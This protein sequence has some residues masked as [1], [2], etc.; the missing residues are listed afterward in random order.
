MIIIENFAEVTAQI[1]TE[2][3][4]SREELMVAVQQAL[5]S[6]CKKRFSEGTTL[7]C[8]IHPETG[9]AQIFVIKTVADKVFNPDIDI[10]LSEAQILDPK[11]EVGDDVKVLAQLESF[12]RIA[13]QTAKQVIIQ[14]IREAEKNAILSEFQEK[15]GTIIIGTVQKIEGDNYL[16][17]LGRVESILTLRDQIHGERFQVNEKIKV[18]VSE[19]VKT[20]RGPSIRIS[21]SHPGL[22]KCLFEQEIPEI[23]DGIIEILSVS[24]EAGRRA[25]VAVKTN[26]PAVGAVGT[27]V[28]H[29]GV[30]IQTI[31]KEIGNEKIDI[32][33]FEEDPKAYISNALK[34]AEISEVII[35]DEEEKTGIV[36]VK[37]DQLSL[38]IGK[39]GMNVRLAVKLTGWR[40]DILSEEDYQAKSSEIKDKTHVSIV[41]RIQEE[42]R[43][44]KDESGEDQ[45]TSDDSSVSEDSEV[46]VSELSKEL[47]FKTQELIDQCKEHGIEIKNNR[48]KLSLETVSEIKEKLG[49]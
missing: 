9:E 26:N 40:I 42:A 41:D 20:P 19:I 43:K 32:I 31:I 2:R 5:V 21:R 45:E 23:E 22:L 3:G 15:V 27:C 1:E 33:E 18:Y 10:E 49:A 29:M 46:K 39:M 8:D 17:N 47:G 4:I 7:E 24:R 44:L 34:P 48:A 13:A 6:A 35:T 30:R 25:K 37:N 11:C 16:I 36:V 28:G 12:G 38:A 14:R